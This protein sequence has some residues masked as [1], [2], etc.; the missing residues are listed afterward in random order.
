MSRLPKFRAWDIQKKVMC[1]VWDIGWKAWDL[2]DN[3][4][5]YVTVYPQKDADGTYELLEGEVIL[6]Q[7]TGLKDRNGVEVYE[8]DLVRIEYNNG[9]NMDDFAVEWM[10]RSAMFVIK[11]DKKGWD[12]LYRLDGIAVNATNGNKLEVIGSKHEGI[13]GE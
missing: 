3:L 6:M 10:D 2:P 8:G 5:N 1:D 9:Y 4:L 7:Y 12:G 13:K 11:N